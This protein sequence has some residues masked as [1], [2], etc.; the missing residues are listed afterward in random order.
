MSSLNSCLNVEQIRV[1]QATVDNFITSVGDGLSCVVAAEHSAR[2]I[3]K[4]MMPIRSWKLCWK[5]V[6]YSGGFR[7]FVTTLNFVSD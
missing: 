6:Y 2:L 5:L 1:L 7:N 4:Q 3:Y